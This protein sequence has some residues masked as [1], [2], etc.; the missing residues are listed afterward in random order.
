MKYLKMI[1]ISF[2][3][4]FILFTLIGLLFPS[5]TKAVKAI[6]INKDSK[7]VLQ[8][9]Q[10]SAKWI[11]WYPFFSG[12]TSASIGAV[13]ND[14]TPLFNHKG[15]LIIYDKR[16]DSNSVSYVSDYKNGSITNLTVMVLPVPGSLVQTQVVW[17]ESQKLKWYPWERFKGLVLEKAKTE[18]L[19]TLLNRFKQYLETLQDN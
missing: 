15:E 4:F 10:L 18:Y 17:H 9:L 1:G 7:T 8:E 2:L 3:V 6:V 16:S 5:S 11:K 19:D 12:D 13:A 14:T